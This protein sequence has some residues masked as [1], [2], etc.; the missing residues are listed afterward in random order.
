MPSLPARPVRPALCTP[1]TRS[2]GQDDSATA[3]ESAARERQRDVVRRGYDAISHA[4]RSDDGHAASSS[5]E[6]VSRYAG[7]VAELAALLL[8]GA[9]VL[10]PGCGAGLPATRELTARG[11]QPA[12]GYGV[13]VRF[14]R[15][16]LG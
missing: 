16:S 12:P 15:Q 9:R 3:D 1:G 5:A 13:A 11:L 10:D 2:A 14:A 8:A 6:D 4:Y 7:W